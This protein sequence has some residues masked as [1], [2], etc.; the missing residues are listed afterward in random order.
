MRLGYDLYE[1]TSSD[2]LGLL[3]LFKNEHITVFQINKVDEYTYR[4]YL[5]IYQR[6]QVKKYHL[7]IIK[8]VGILHYLLLLF[9]R[10]LNI[11]GVISFIL[12][13]MIC[14]QYLFKIEI[15]G[16]NPTTNQAIKSFLINSGIKN[17]SKRQSYEQLN[18]IYDGIKENLNKKIDYL[19]IY[20]EGST[21]YIKYTNSVGA[22]RVKKSFQNI[23]ASKDGVIKNINVSSGNV[24]VK[25]NDYVKK[26]DLLVSNTISSTSGKDK[27]IETE[28]EIQAYTYVSYQAS[29]DKE[30]FD[31]GEAFSYLLYAIRCKLGIIDK[32]DRENILEYGIIDDKRVLKMQY[33]LIE[34]IASKKEN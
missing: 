4:F 5:P 23:Y 7:N 20:Q 27:I 22:K 19:N 12:T 25:V 11:L 9:F 31:S 14:S 2:I 17:G 30:K 18:E 13:I 29:V 8:S 26:G 34:N 6:I 15:V 32:I 16:N 10:K 3:K 21:L 24:V 28:G 33:V 1:V